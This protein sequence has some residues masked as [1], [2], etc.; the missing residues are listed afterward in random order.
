[1]QSETNTTY[2]IQQALT[3]EFDYE[4]PFIVVL[5]R[6]YYGKT[7]LVSNILCNYLTNKKYKYDRIILFSDTAKF[8]GSYKDYVCDDNIYTTDM[9]DKNIPI[10]MEH[11]QNTPEKNREH[12]IIVLDDVQITTKSKYLVALSTMGRHYNI[13]CIAS[14]QYGKGLLSAAIRNNID[15]FFVGEISRL[16]L[17]E[18]V[19]SWVI[20]FTSFKEFF[21][22]FYN[23]YV[24]KPVFCAYNTLG[25]SKENRLGLIKA[26]ILKDVKLTGGC[27]KRID[28][29]KKQKKST[30]IE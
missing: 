26:D 23:R 11:Q 18:I 13:L 15:V 21:I 28:K 19:M 30:K 7:I 2:N 27:K 10:I 9:L 16:L 6:R 8:K 3:Y 14:L 22:E 17:E 25:T 24:S 4:F 29:M 20:P 1:M 12:I 5:S